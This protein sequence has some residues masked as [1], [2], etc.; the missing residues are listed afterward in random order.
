MTAPGAEG[1]PAENRFQRVPSIARVAE[2][3][4]FACLV[5][6][7]LLLSEPVAALLF[8]LDGIELRPSL[9]VARERA[10]L[11]V[12][13]AGLILVLA[14]RSRKLAARRFPGALGDLVLL[15]AAIVLATGL[16][17][18]WLRF[19]GARHWGSAT[20]TPLTLGPM[21]R[22][23]GLPLRPGVFATRVVSDFD[24]G[25]DRRILITINRY[26]LRGSAPSVP[27][28]P[29]RVRVVALGGSTTF[30]YSVADGEDWPSQLGRILGERY[31]V[32]NAGRPGATSFRNFSYLRDHLLRLEPDLVVLY[33]GFN[34]M[35]RAVRRHA[36]DQPDYG[37]VDE[38]LPGNQGPLDQGPPLPWPWRPSFLAYRGAQWSARH[39]GERRPAWPEP[40]VGP[41]PF[42]FDP[43]VVAIYER[44][45][46][47]MVRLCRSRGVRPVL[48]TFAACDDP[49]SPPAEAQRRL[50][51]VMREMPQLDTD[52]GR[53]AM[54]LYREV[55][56]QVARE[57]AVPLV[58]LARRMTKDLSAY[59]DTVHF[60][61]AGERALAELLAEELP[62]A[63]GSVTVTSPTE[64]AGADAPLS[65][66]PRS[67]L[68]PR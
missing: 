21:V 66:A 29:G 52:T 37:I 13:V 22:E 54:D 26:G 12:G 34:D 31:E 36:G 9:E 57:E 47:A 68:P 41:G 28:P 6:S 14:G 42:R 32:L 38:H 40:A 15:C 55:T 33:E 3:L 45:L 39:L 51:Y 59:V 67:G 27:K 30:G 4:G 10:Q 18:G 20:R 63:Y 65:K 50:R 48:A 23:D 2:V 5:G 16:A 24:A 58:D 25:Y 35:W 1:R 43:A 8:S 60:T 61:P 46:G 49:S 19:R 56:R 7:V 53:Q 44:N 64:S 62:R 11:A 17:E